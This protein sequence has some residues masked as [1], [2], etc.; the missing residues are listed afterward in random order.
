MRPNQRTA[1]IIVILLLALTGVGLFVTTEQG[2]RTVAPIA[3]PAKVQQSPVDLQQFRTAQ[4]LAMLAVTPEEQDLARDTLRKADHEVDFA[5]A[6]ALYTA[7]TQHIPSTPEIKEILERISKGQQEDGELD[8]DVA[9][10]TKL[11]ASTK[12]DQKEGLTQQLDLTKSRQELIEDELAD[13]HQ[14]LER[15]GGDPQ[16][17]IQRMVDDYNA[18]EQSSGG[19]LDLN[20]VGRQSSSAQPPSYSFLGRSQAW[21]ALQSIVG[22]L[23]REQQYAAAQAG[24]FSKS[25]DELEKQLDEGQSQQKK[26]LSESYS[27]NAMASG[28]AKEFNLSI[29]SNQRGN[30]FL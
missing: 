6:S 26:K 8:A 27:G 13:A 1:V 24:D 20:I 10:L 11:L 25:H 15:A 30:F 4:S 7:S 9:R 3:P 16:S 17:R 18:S 21:F 22:R 2:A 29:E 19:Q 23:G 12:E 28:P 14:D 5:F